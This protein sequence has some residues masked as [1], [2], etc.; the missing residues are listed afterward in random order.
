MSTARN[1]RIVFGLVVA[2]GA[3]LSARADNHWTA[4]GATGSMDETALN[5]VSFTKSVVGLSRAT[6]V[7]STVIA[8]WNV[9]NVNAP[10]DPTWDTLSLT[11]YDNS[12][13]N[14]IYV[15]LMQMDRTN[16]ATTTVA[17]LI[18]TDSASTKWDT[19]SFTHTFDFSLYTYYIYA[20]IYG[21]SSASQPIIKA[22]T[23]RD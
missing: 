5:P 13:T 7:T 2:P 4:F 14:K 11:N 20:Y 8:Y 15:F 19:T 10:D 1:L 18:S 22:V 12:T 3:P 9:E 16:G 17:S 23:V 21:S 6:G